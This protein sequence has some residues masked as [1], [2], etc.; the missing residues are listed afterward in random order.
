MNSVQPLKLVDGIFTAEDAK[1]ILCHLLNKKI[2]FHQCRIFDLDER[3]GECDDYSVKRIEELKATKQAMLETI[4][5]AKLTGKH[6]RLDAEILIR[7]TDE[8]TT[9]QSLTEQTAMSN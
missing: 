5:L 2:N 1:D 9:S 3:C 8:K 7:F 6:L 4:E